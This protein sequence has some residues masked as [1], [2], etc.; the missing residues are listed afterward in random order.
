MLAQIFENTVHTFAN[1]LTIYLLGTAAGAWLYATQPVRRWL[2]DP[3]RATSLLLYSLAIA[4]FAA[5]AT[6]ANAP[7]AMAALAPPGSSYLR[8]AIA[9]TVFSALVFLPVTISMGAAYSHLLGH[10]TYAGAGY[11]SAFNTLGASL[12]PVLFGL[13]SFHPPVMAWR[14]TA[15]SGCT[16][17][18]LSRRRCAPSPS[19]GSSRPSASRR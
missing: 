13:A 7:A 18:S 16:F 2:G 10:F 9:E 1:I 12:A 14:S 19:D 15:R 6:L 17:C 5:A 8:L 4:G 3:D 11:A